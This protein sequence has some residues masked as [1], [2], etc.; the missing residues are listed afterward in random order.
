MMRRRGLVAIAVVFSFGLSSCEFDIF[1][2]FSP[3]DLGLS[4]DPAER[5]A[6]DT[7]E[8]QAKDREAQEMVREG[9]QE[10]ALEK[11]DEASRLRPRDPRYKYYKGAAQLAQGDEEGFK[12]SFGEGIGIGVEN[13]NRLPDEER[14]RRRADREGLRRAYELTLEALNFALDIEREREPAD[15]EAIDR[16]EKKFCGAWSLYTR[17]LEMYATRGWEDSLAFKSFEAFVYT[18]DCQA[19]S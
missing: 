1:E 15:G 11:L 6:G 16:L 4:D 17:G 13:E 8:A 2:L 12:K 19:R 10:G 5:A 18:V 7:A 3:V 14:F 9:M